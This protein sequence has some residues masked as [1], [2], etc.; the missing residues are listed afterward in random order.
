MAWWRHQMEAFSALL[1][2]CAGNSPVT[3]DPH[4]GQWRGTLMFY[5]ICA[6]ING[7][8]NNREARDFRRHR[9]YYDVIVMG[10]QNIIRQK[11]SQSNFMTLV[12]RFCD[13]SRSA[14][15]YNADI[16]INFHLGIECGLLM[17]LSHANVQ[18]KLRTHSLEFWRSK[19]I[20]ALVVSHGIFVMNS[21]SNPKTLSCSQWA[22]IFITSSW[23][24][25]IQISRILGSS[26]HH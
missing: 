15:L 5:F 21:A 22:S 11:K 7:W 4:K 10:H 3:G 6:R 8:V 26:H 2:P 1:A 13:L 24:L 18:R 23:S 25:T 17:R 9:T 20:S 14:I 12:W 19:M 16:I